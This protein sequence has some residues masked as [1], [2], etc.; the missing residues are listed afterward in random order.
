M[1]VHA[2]SQP[3][4]RLEF[5]QTQAHDLLENLL[6]DPTARTV[7]VYVPEACHPG[8]RYPLLI[9]LAG[10]TGS[11]LSHLAWKGFGETIP[12]RVDRLMAEGQLAP[13]VY[14]FPD[15]FTSLGGNQYVDSIAMGQWARWLHEI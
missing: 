14:V 5:F 6:G 4:G 8:E 11:G 1:P 7:G 2:F 3:K 10:F 9:D 12:Q 13:A 15:C